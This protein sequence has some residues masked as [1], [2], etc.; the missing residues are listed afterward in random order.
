[1]ARQDVGGPSRLLIFLFIAGVHLNAEAMS[2]KSVD[3]LNQAQLEA[4][5][6][7][8]GLQVQFQKRTHER[9]ALEEQEDRT[10]AQMEGTYFDPKKICALYKKCDKVASRTK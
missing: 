5:K 3:L 10:V 7:L 9:L 4:Q 8:R 2:A 6:E 1:M